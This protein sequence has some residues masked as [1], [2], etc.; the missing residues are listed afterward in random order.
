MYPEISSN[1]AVRVNGY[2]FY[3]DLDLRPF[4]S[5]D[6]FAVV[7]LSHK[8]GTIFCVQRGVVDVSRFVLS[9]SFAK[10]MS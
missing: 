10:F 5:G 1:F 4:A 6:S 9:L 3:L 7:A 2:I 8:S